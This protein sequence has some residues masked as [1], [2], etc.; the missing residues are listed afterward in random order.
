MEGC[1]IVEFQDLLSHSLEDTFCMSLL[2]ADKSLLL[3]IREEGWTRVK[4]MVLSTSG[5]LWIICGR[6]SQ[7]EL[8]L[9]TG[10]GSGL[11]SEIP[12]LS[13]IELALEQTTP[14]SN[15]VEHASK[16][17]ERALRTQRAEQV[18]YKYLEKNAVLH[19]N[20]LVDAKYLNDKLFATLYPQKPKMRK[21][22]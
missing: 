19:I 17:L 15:L 14:T 5:I 22:L 13:F 1:E 4:A 9:V 8:G 21:L 18:E 2:E 3:D 16:V 12:G 11:L 20:R 10:L 7:L 6:E